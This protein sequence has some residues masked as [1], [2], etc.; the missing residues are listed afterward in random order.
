[1]KLKAYTIA[2][3]VTTMHR[4]GKGQVECNHSSALSVV[5][6][7]DSHV[8]YRRFNGKCSKEKCEFEEQF[9]GKPPES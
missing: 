7:M 6:V 8:S 3:I 4:I 1:L 2:G 9:F 5:E